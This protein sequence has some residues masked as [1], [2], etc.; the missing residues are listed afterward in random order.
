MYETK[1]EKLLKMGINEM[2]KE[3]NDTVLTSIVFEIEK[4]M[5]DEERVNRILSIESVALEHEKMNVKGFFDMLL[6]R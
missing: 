1:A 3:R 4:M 2:K 5:E 6:N